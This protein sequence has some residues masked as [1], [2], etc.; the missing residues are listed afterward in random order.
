MNAAAA[1]ALIVHGG[2]PLLYVYRRAAAR[3]GSTEKR[4]AIRCLALARYEWSRR[5]NPLTEVVKLEAP[6][7]INDDLY[8]EPLTAL[9]IEAIRHAHESRDLAYRRVTAKH[10]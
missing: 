4:V 7:A 10:V 6:T 2:K 3:Y 1:L 8:R 5:S 9:R